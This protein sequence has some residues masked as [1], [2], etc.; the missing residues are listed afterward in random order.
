[1]LCVCYG[2]LVPSL[3]GHLMNPHVSVKPHPAQNHLN[4]YAAEN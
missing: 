4:S 1:M 2:R 3:T